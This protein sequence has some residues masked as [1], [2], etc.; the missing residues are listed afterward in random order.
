MRCV[1]VAPCPVPTPRTSGF[2]APVLSSD[3]MEAGCSSGW[4]PAGCLGLAL[5]S[6]LH[7]PGC[8]GCPGPGPILCMPRATWPKSCPQQGRSS[9]SSTVQLHIEWVT[10]P[11]LEGIIYL[12]GDPRACHRLFLQH[13]VPFSRHAGPKLP[14]PTTTTTTI[15]A[16]CLPFVAPTAQ[17]PA[18][19]AASQKRA[20]R[21]QGQPTSPVRYMRIPLSSPILPRASGPNQPSPAAG[22]ADD[23][24]RALAPRRRASPQPY[25]GT[26]QSD[27]C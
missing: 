26:T 22:A 5:Q 27:A 24:R 7:C 4:S 8:P 3:G 19:P 11:V 17:H 6:L 14:A 9:G 1:L 10:Q 21:T 18:P 2:R 12:P 16:P 23:G 15:T 25:G 20:T 13:R